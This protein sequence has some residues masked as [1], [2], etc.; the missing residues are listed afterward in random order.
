MKR[1]LIFSLLHSWQ[2]PQIHESIHQVSSLTTN[3]IKFKEGKLIEGQQQKCLVMCFLI[4][5]ATFA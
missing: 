3:E 5:H 2:Q 4:W 1:L